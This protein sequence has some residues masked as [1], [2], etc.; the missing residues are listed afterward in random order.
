MI[1]EGQI[2]VKA[3]NMYSQSAEATFFFQTVSVCRLEC[4]QYMILMVEM[5]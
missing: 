5:Q 3:I 2:L 1:T 4:L